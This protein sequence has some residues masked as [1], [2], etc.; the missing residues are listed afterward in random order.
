M[1]IAGVDE[2]GRGP[3]AGPVTVA[4]VI[5]RDEIPGLD[6]SKKLSEAKR[7]TLAP[8][9][10]EQ[11]LAWS[12]IHVDVAVI[13]QINILQATMQGMQQAV[14]ALSTQ[15]DEVLVDGNKCPD[16]QLPAQA[17]IGGDGKV[18][19]ISAASILAKSARD[20][21]MT[22]LHQE[23]PAYGFDRHKGY[24]TQ[25]HLAVLKAQG[26]SPHHRKSFAPVRNLLQAEWLR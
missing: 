23:Y 14:K 18:A 10:M 2:A 4:A 19:A 6:D 9:I 15:P 1:L 12:V 7:L 22:E 3:L 26:P 24:G 11:A 13:D 16:F 17:I 8:Q 25:Q 20:A 21:L 5:L